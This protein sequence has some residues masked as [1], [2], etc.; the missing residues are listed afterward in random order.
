MR[1]LQLNLNHCEAVQDLLM[2]SVRELKIDVAIISELH[3]DLDTQPWR[4]D[5]T[6][7]AAIWSRGGHHF[8]EVMNR[9]ELW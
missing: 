3:R 7:R 1:I 6:S 4:S 9:S 8:Q 5:S 2:Q